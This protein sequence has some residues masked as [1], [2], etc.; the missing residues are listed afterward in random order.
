VFCPSLLKLVAKISVLE[1]GN[2]PNYQTLESYPAQLVMNNWIKNLFDLIYLPE[3]GKIELQPVSEI[4]V[5]SGERKAPSQAELIAYANPRD[6]STHIFKSEDYARNQL[7][8]FRAKRNLYYKF[9]WPNSFDRDGFLTA[10]LDFRKRVKEYDQ[11]I[12]R[13][14]PRALWPM[15]AKFSAE[16]LSIKRRKDDFLQETAGQLAIGREPTV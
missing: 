4:E 11:R 14:N 10:L 8:Y 13:I 16:E 5:K 9:G 6:L 2:L 12:K 15:A 3:Y 7:N 1:Y